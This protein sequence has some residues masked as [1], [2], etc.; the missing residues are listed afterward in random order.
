[1]ITLFTPTEFYGWPYPFPINLA[2]GGGGS[3][4]ATPINGIVVASVVTPASNTLRWTGS[5]GVNHYDL[6]RSSTPL[7]LGTKIN[8]APLTDSGSPNFLVNVTDDGISTSS[9]PPVGTAVYYRLIAVDALG[10]VSIVS[11]AVVSIIE[12]SAF[13]QDPVLATLVQGL[14]ADPTLLAMIGGDRTN[15]RF[16]KR[17]RE[18][19]D[20][21]PFVVLW[22]SNWDEDPKMKDLRFGTLTYKISVVNNQASSPAVVNVINRIAALL[23]GEPGK[24][25]FKGSPSIMVFQCMF[26]GAGPESFS[27]APKLWF[28]DGVLKLKCQLF[29]T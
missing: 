2:G 20:T 5:N 22:R 1:M 26:T 13:V 19:G 24:A 7:V 12:S 6:Y 29:A 25:I 23:D 8:L 17:I 18:V 27:D 14:R 10:D 16:Q 15:V 3:V 9:A 21:Y 28:Q 11:D 4:P